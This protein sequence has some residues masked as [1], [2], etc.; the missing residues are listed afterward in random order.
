[1]VNSICGG[2]PYMKISLPGGL[3]G[4]RESAAAST[5]SVAATAAS[6]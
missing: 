3:S 4:A 5:A 6:M 2:A 1:M